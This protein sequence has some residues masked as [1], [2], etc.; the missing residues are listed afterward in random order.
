MISTALSISSLSHT[1]TLCMKTALALM[2]SVRTPYCAEGILFMFSIP[3]FFT[4]STEPTSQAKVDP[5]VAQ[6]SRLN[7]FEALSISWRP[8]VRLNG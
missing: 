3:L 1:R 5:M 7:L 8:F 2:M 4:S 6:L